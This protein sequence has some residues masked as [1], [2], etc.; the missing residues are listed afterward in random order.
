MQLKQER[1]DLWGEQSHLFSETKIKLNTSKLLK[2][3]KQKNNNLQK[4]SLQY[5]GYIKW[6]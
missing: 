1:A 4:G 6:C 2:Q 3:N 5:K